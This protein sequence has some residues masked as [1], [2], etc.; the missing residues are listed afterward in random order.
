MREDQACLVWGLCVCAGN[1]RSTI[2]V[3]EKCE[4]E[5]V[6]C[7]NIGEDFGPATL[8]TAARGWCASNARAASHLGLKHPDGSR[9]ACPSRPACLGPAPGAMHS[10][11]T[12]D[13]PAPQARPDWAKSH[14]RLEHPDDS[15][16]VVAPADCGAQRVG[17]FAEL[18]RGS[19]AAIVHLPARAAV[20]RQAAL[21]ER[22][23]I[24][25]QTCQKG[26]TG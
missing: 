20:G 4:V 11:R 19:E 21:H 13:L 23:T 16:V 1:A 24:A 12:L 5:R 17:V 18:L 9:P 14:L 8:A 26:Q 3:G 2:G 10:H 7:C 15:V 22:H 25:R 6:D